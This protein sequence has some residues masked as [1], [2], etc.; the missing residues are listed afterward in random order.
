[1]GCSGPCTTT[2]RRRRRRRRGWLLIGLRI[3]LRGRD[4]VS[5]REH[6]AETRS[7]LQQWQSFQDR[8]AHYDRAL[9]PLTTERTRAA[10][11]AYRGGGGTL[12]SVL[13]ARRMEIDTRMERLRL[14]MEAAGL[15]A[16]LEYLIPTEH[17]TA[18]T[19]RP[20]ATKEQQR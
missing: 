14:E 9:I 17:R 10:I 15:W 18:M 7:W 5:T 1:M 8:A 6:V 16:R 13:E 12:P 11:A 3:G 4:R 2:S 20:V 19:D